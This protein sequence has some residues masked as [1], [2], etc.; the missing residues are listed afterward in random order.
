MAKSPKVGIIILNWNQEKDTTA[1]LSSLSKIDYSNYEI[2]VVDNGSRDGSPEK[3]KAKFHNITL[4]KNKENLGFAEGNNVGIRYL[5]AKSVDY[6][7]LLNNDTIVES[8]F[9]TELVRVGE[10]STDIGILAPKIYFLDKPDQIWYA[11]GYFRRITGKTYHRGLFEKD[12]GQYDEVAGVD[13]VSGCAML[14]KKEI[15]EKLKGLDPDYFNSH[16]DVDFCLR[17]KALHYKLLYVPTSK[18]RHKF[19]QAMGGRFSSFYIYYRVRNSL[20]F[21]EKNGFPWW[22]LAYSL[23]TN[24]A[25]MIAFTLLTGNFRGTAAAIKGLR[26]FLGRKFGRGWEI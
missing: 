6:I 13:F 11:G 24:P 20:L 12:S 25:K 7:L 3:I 4:I 23:I 18:I 19:A 17:T 21:M 1:C 22:K 16:E 15:L 5:M 8:N 14:I 9:L 2:V 10:S 26:D